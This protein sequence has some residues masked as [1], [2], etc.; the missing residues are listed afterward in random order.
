MALPPL[1]GKL[2]Y[3][4]GGS[5]EPP[6]G[7]T[8]VSRDRTASIAEGLYNLCYVNG[9]QIQPEEEGFWMS[10]HP[11]LILRTGDGSPVIDTEWN[12]MLL[13]VGSGDKRTA[14]ATI[15]GEWIAGCK[16]AGF[17]A[18]EIDN[19][20]SFSRSGGLLTEDDAVAMMKLMADAAHG[21]ELAIAQ[22][23]SAELVGRR[24]E[25]TT[26]FVVAEECNQFSE[27]QDYRDAY[28]DHVLVIEYQRSSFDA[29]CAA[30]PTLSIVLRDRDLVAP[31]DAAYVYDGC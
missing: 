24:S 6:T 12:E 17:D 8:I 18:I 5:Y 3:Q 28:G 26:D 30:F 11:D 13:D 25:L 22:K 19:L 29:G 14:I 9:F 23:N 21:G 31:P 15:V 27:C 4:L 16:T 10:M 1:S 20:D 2:D 7:V